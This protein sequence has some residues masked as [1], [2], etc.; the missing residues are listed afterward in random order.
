[1]LR[2]LAYHRVVP[3]T[4]ES[5]YPFD[6]TLIS[7]WQA[8]FQWQLDYLKR[9]YDPVRC[10]DVIEA[11][12]A[13]RP[14]P[15]RAVLLTFDDGFSDNYHVAFPALRDRGIPATI[16]LTTGYIGRSETFWFD[17]LIYLVARTRLESIELPGVPVIR[18]DSSRESRIRQAGILLRHLKSVSDSTRRDL[19]SALDAQ[20]GVEIDQSDR[21]LSEPMTWTDVKTMAG[22]GIE[23]GSH[24][25]SHPILS[26][27]TDKEELRSELVESKRRI[28][29]ECGM[30]ALSI[31]YPVG[32]ADAIDNRVVQMVREAGY[33]LGFTY[34]T[35]LNAALPSDPFRIRRLRV[36]RY[37]NRAL[38][39]AML[40]LPNIVAYR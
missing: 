24:S 4:V 21:R 29:V 39:A 17:H 26:R 1:V 40:E 11:L 16:F 37:T 13:G 19:I 23:F 34:E 31:A 36:E 6:L 27:V 7:A 18:L 3:H 35:G 22:A 8:E 10:A 15:K 12:D 30:P 33:R 20:L 9:N 2:V 25:V 14:L 38:F 28:E 32:G 5:R